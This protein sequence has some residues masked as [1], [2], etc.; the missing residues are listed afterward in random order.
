MT[1]VHM[2]RKWRTA[3]GFTLVEAA[4]STVI[5]GVIMTASLACVARTAT[6][7]KIQNDQQT[8]QALAAQ[9][10]AEILEKSY[11]DPASSSLGSLGPASAEVATGNRSL[12]DDVDDY[13]EWLESP[14]ALADGTALSETTGWYRKVDV[15]FV[16]WSDLNTA[17][18][19]D[20]GLKRISVEVG[21]VQPGG[22]VNA[23]KSRIPVE[24]LVAVTGYGR[25]M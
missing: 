24:T 1:S 18:S 10:M 25:G 12:F 22:N 8:A 2:T 23:A 6:F 13:D 20:V 17:V 5:V 11:L 14:P 16:D 9:L 7:R 19:T 21:R 4:I 3:G 15:V